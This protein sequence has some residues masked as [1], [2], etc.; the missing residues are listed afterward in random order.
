MQVGY[1]RFD[2]DAELKVLNQIWELDQQFTNY[3]LAQQQLVSKIREGSKVTKRYDRAKTPYQRAKAWT[4]L[5]ASDSQRLDQSLTGTQPGTL[6]RQ[7]TEL[8]IRL[9]NLALT[10]TAAPVKPPV[11]RAFNNRPEPEIPHEATNQPSRRI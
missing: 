4:G 6:S 11:N 7:I 10:K 3:V 8:T 5:T 9:E 1:L 2:T